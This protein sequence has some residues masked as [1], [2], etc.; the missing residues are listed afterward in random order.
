M[1]NEIKPEIESYQVLVRL[2]PC[3]KVCD[4]TS[5][6]YHCIIWFVS[7]VWR[8]MSLGFTDVSELIH[9]VGLLQ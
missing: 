1:Q 8:S 9:F 5:A 6:L 3:I 7:K 2:N 4:I